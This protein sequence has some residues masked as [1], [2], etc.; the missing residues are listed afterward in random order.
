MGYDTPDL[1]NQP[2]AFGLTEVDELN[3]PDASWSFDKF[4]VWKS[5]DGYYWGVDAGCSCPS[6][7]ERHT[8]LSY[9]NEITSLDEF[10]TD[11][12]NWFNGVA[13]YTSDY[14]ERTNWDSDKLPAKFQSLKADAMELIR[15]VSRG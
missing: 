3:D 10:E 4:V 15:K 1:Y 9:A 8:S 5:E 13:P 11:V 14:S 7:F 2:E 6:P 12:K